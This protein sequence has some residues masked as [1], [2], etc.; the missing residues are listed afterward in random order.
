[1]STSAGL[2]PRAPVVDL[3]HVNMCRSNRMRRVGSCFSKRRVYSGLCGNIVAFDRAV[4]SERQ[5]D[6]WP[7][8]QHRIQGDGFLHD[9]AVNALCLH[10]RLCGR[11]IGASRAQVAAR[12]MPHANTMLERLPQLAV[13]LLYL[14]GSCVSDQLLAVDAREC[15]QVP[16]GPKSAGRKHSTCCKR[17]HLCAIKCTTWS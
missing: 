17:M 3:K 15:L 10:G 6:R 1:M 9:N 11:G 16:P 13:R 2:G 5:Y 14:R 12:H 4:G 8:I 7:F